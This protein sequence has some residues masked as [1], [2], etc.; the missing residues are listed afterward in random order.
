MKSLLAACAALALSACSTGVVPTGQDTYMIAKKSAA[1]MFTSGG[2]VKA[3]LYT[4]ATEY[5]ARDNRVVETIT[6]TSANAIPFARMP[7]A[8]LNFR[9]AARAPTAAASAP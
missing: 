9:C 8:E 4:E 2:T 6:A 3:S 5:C 7:Q 1:G